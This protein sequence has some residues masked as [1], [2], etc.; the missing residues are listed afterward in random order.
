MLETRMIV[1]FH[2]FDLEGNRG[3]EH[4]VSLFGGHLMQREHDGERPDLQAAKR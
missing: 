3:G 1:E 4:G 2:V